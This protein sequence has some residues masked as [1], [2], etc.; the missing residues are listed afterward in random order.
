MKPSNHQADPP[1][2]FK[3]RMVAVFGEAGRTYLDGLGETIARY[4]K[5]WGLTVK[6][7]APN[8]SYN[9]VLF[10]TCADGR[11]AVLKIGVPTESSRNEVLA[12]SAYGGDGCAEL[13][14]AVPEDGVQ[15][16]DR[17]SPGFMLRTIRDEREATERFCEVWAR[18]RRPLPDG[19]EIRPVGRMA[20]EA[21]PNTGPRIR[22]AVRFRCGMSHLRRNASAG[23]R[24]TA[25]QNCSTATSIIRISCW[26]KSAAGWQSI[27][28]AMRATL[29]VT[30]RLTST[31]SWKENRSKKRLPCARPSCS[32]GFRSAG[33]GFSVPASR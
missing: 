27:R 33:N 9:Y 5:D 30:W 32:P 20:L 19:A 29:P 17:L 7:P 12:V 8:L 14:R 15:L 31:M 1:K 23:W 2:E 10:V 16:I 18:I 24:S 26:I 25:G 21:L 4:T 22:V 11:K 28:T 13:L 6:G 3:E